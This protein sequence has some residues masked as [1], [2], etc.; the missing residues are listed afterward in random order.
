MLGPLVVAE[1]GHYLHDAMLAQ[2]ALLF[3]SRDTNWHSVAQIE[4]LFLI[5][6]TSDLTY[7]VL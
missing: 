6:S 7:I 5:C 2:Y 3:F 4:L 1:V